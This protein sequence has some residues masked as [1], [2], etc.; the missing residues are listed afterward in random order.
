MT[1]F[2]TTKESKKKWVAGLTYFATE[3]EYNNW[4]E[5]YKFKRPQFVVM[6]KNLLPEDHETPRSH[7][8]KKFIKW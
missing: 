6:V 8:F 5:I 4:E 2:W 1:R 7:P 3:H